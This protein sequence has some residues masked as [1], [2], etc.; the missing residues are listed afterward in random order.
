[1]Q[2][3]LATILDKQFIKKWDLPLSA[4]VSAL[5]TKQESASINQK[6]SQK[7]KTI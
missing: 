4:K 6:H 7:R 2:Q 5:P 1:M 3:L